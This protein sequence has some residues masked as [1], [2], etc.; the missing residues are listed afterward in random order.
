MKLSRKSIF[1][2]V[3]VLEISGLIV[4]SGLTINSKLNDSSNIQ[5]QAE[6]LT[7]TIEK[8]QFYFKNDTVKSN[9]YIYWAELE[10]G[11]KLILYGN[12]SDMYQIEFWDGIGNLTQK[13]EVQII[14]YEV[15]IIQII[16]LIQIS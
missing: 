6:D 2:L 8:D 3:I 15:I 4:V 10:G 16:F 11:N 12:T 7:V 5:A 13:T 9:A 1:L 14:R